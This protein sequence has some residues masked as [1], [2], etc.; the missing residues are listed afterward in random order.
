MTFSQ[1]TRILNAIIITSICLNAFAKN[2]S[3]NASPIANSGIYMTIQDSNGKSDTVTR[4]YF[5]YMYR[6]NNQEAYEDSAKFSRHFTDFMLK[7]QEAKRQGL[8][9][10]KDFLSQTRQFKEKT[11]TPYLTDTSDF[12]HLEKTIYQRTLEDIN[13]SHILIKISA[14]QSPQDTMAAYNK[15]LTAMKRLKYDSFD[16][17]AVWMS[18]D[19]S[20][21]RNHGNLGWITSMWMVKDFE[22]AAYNTSK[23][24]IVGPV[25]TPFGYHII[26]IN[27]RRPNMGEIQIAHIMKAVNDSSEKSD[28]K[29]KKEIEE[30]YKRLKN[31]EPWSDALLLSDDKETK[32]MGG[33][34]PSFTMGKMIDQIENAAFR[35]KEIGDISE[36]VRTPFGWH[37]IKLIDKKGPMSFDERKQE[38]DDFISRSDRKQWLKQRH[39]ESLKKIYG[40]K[41]NDKLLAKLEKT[42]QKVQWNDSIFD[43]NTC[44]DNDKAIAS[45]YHDNT[46]DNYTL[47]N[48]KDYIQRNNYTIAQIRDIT[49]AAT[50]DTVFD[51]N[52]RNIE[53]RYPEIINQTQEFDDGLL[54]WDISKQEIWDKAAQDT[55]MLRNEFEN[56][57]EKYKW[58]DK[59]WKGRIVYCKSVQTQKKVEKILNENSDETEVDKQLQRLNQKRINIKSERGLYAKGQNKAIDANVFDVANQD[60]QPLASDCKIQSISNLSDKP[61][62]EWGY[63]VIKGKLTDT[64]DSYREVRGLVIQNYQEKLNNQWTSELRNKYKVTYY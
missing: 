61:H 39:A 4:A 53:L 20:V 42:A 52:K 26:K 14:P 49:A 25:R 60:K 24:E 45:F 3:K 62:S 13:V 11:I 64:P 38:I 8:A 18:D 48:L 41:T 16:S 15:T 36:P 17:V 2:T 9:D 58:T 27:D 12:N 35:L 57:R 40:Y 51:I 21:R 5:D 54:L 37:I 22:D 47:K 55:T 43:Q 32:D 63:A 46:I 1:I 23:G 33:K 10:S 50:S 30:I 29:S 28:M 44:Q 7:V 6:K 34:L 56:N 31:G 59:R 19:P